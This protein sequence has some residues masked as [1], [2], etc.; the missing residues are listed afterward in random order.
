MT[1]NLTRLL[2]LL[3]LIFGWNAKVTAV[4]RGMASQGGEPEKRILVLYSYNYSQS[5]QKTIAEGL[6]TAR[7]TAGLGPDV[8]V[9]EYLDISP[10]KNQNHRDLLKQMLLGKYEG[11]RFDLLITVFDDALTFLLEDGADLSPASPCLALYNQE[12]TGLVRGGRPVLQSPLHVDPKGT[13]DMALK[14]FPDTRTVVFVAGN[15]ALDRNI[16]SRARSDFARYRDRVTIEY[17]SDLTADMMLARVRRLEAGELVIYGRVSSDATGLRINS[18]DMAFSLAREARVPVFCLATSHLDT[19]VVGGSMVRV[20]D[21]ALMLG[22]VLPRLMNN[23]PVEL[24]PAS[25]FVRPMFEWNQLRRWGIRLRDLPEDSI[26]VN[27]PQTLWSQYRI[28]V[29]AAGLTFLLLV[30]FI[31]ALAVQSSRR[32]AAEIE[33]RENESRF[34]ILIEQA[35]DA[36]VVYDHDLKRIVEANETAVELFGC[37]RDVLLQSGPWNFYDGDDD[38]QPERQIQRVLNG[39]LLQAE[40]NLLRPDKTTVLCELRLVRLPSATKR[41]IRASLIDITQ[42]KKDEEL[43]HLFKDLVGHSTDAIGMST[44]EG[45]H[46]YQNSAFDRL[47]GNIGEIP[48]DT[49]YVDKHIGTTVFDTIMAGDSWMG[50]VKMFKHDGSILDIFLRAYA[51]KDKNGRVIGL[52]GLHTDITK[53]KKAEAELRLFRDLVENATDAIGVA[54]P[55][56]KHYYQ[57]PAFDRLLGDVGDDP[58]KSI[59]VDKALGRKIFDTIM[60]GGVWQGEVNSY[61]RNGEILAILLR[62]FAVRNSEGQVIALAGI[63]TDI[64]SRKQAEKDI[65]DWIRRYELIVAASGQVAYEYD[66]ASGRITWGKSIEQVL[67][68]RLDEID[69][70]FVQW[71][72]LLHPEDREA[73]LD[74]LESAERECTYWDATYRLRHK[75]GHDVWIRDRGFFVPDGTG[76]ARCQLGML[77][78]VTESRNADAELKFRNSLLQTQLETTI[79]GILFVDPEG[80]ILSY[81]RRF[82]DMWGIPEDILKSRFDERALQFALEK[83][84]DSHEFLDRVQYLYDHPVDVAQEEIN[85]KDGRIFE[86]YTAPVCA[87]D[88]TCYGRVWYFHDIT[89]R[90]TAEEERLRLHEQLHQSQKMEYVGRLAGGVAHDFNNMLGV[91]LGHLDMLMEDMNPISPVYSELIEIRKAA[92]R[93]AELTRQ[94]L[95]FA[96]KQ[97]AAPRVLDLNETVEGMLK[98][99]RRLIGEDIDLSWIPG[100]NLSSVKIDP[101]Q[102]DQVLVNLCLNARQAIDGVGR[103]S[104]RTAAASFDE[105]YVRLHPDHAPGHYVMMEVEDNGCGMDRE[106]RDRIFEPFFT[107]KDIGQG[108]GLGLATVYG[109]VKQNQGFITVYSEPGMGALFRIY[110][111]VWLGQDEILKKMI[112][113]TE[114]PRA[115]HET[116]L[117]VEDEPAI[118]DMIRRMLERDGYTVLSA[119]LPDQAIRL[120]REHQGPI[121]L[122]ITDVIMPGMNGRDLS[123]VLRKSAPSLL[124][125]FMSGYTAD[126]ISHHGVLEKGFILS[127][128]RLHGKT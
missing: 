39:E 64:T 82:L 95:A 122:L 85:L 69:G 101:S 99:L 74:S 79:D 87:E 124:C 113:E 8:F 20:E 91:I 83:V 72:G 102:V 70:G 28:E 73:T 76:K 41:L 31:L 13:L 36:I 105:E 27:Q 94:L 2:I 123:T 48:P 12:R 80:R 24:Q 3:W 117:L 43:L 110:L 78:D 40:W 56:G 96:R 108:T 53:R 49:L 65:E 9:H 5:A 116:I 1:R 92:E 98:M 93:S 89:A 18:R 16:E 88:G 57:N 33:A 30:F 127:R 120:A 54:T 44:P 115:G 23:E 114:A 15:S 42:R 109:I 104:I 25:R 128:S 14:L 121:D 103:I 52:V 21:L 107:T 67:G 4:P 19:G 32:K 26:V 97:I 125:L 17:T 47:F 106:T 60:A 81:N 77:E 126:V 111:P 61:G 55:E 112:P 84:A 59:Y 51:I 62:A 75:E 7:T 35:P 68:Y 38:G 66:V 11:V 29:I 22:R 71:K 90:K 50:E 58:A 37:P 100:K 34:R 46:Y 118:L 6:E 63:N 86:R 119:S 10:P 45:R